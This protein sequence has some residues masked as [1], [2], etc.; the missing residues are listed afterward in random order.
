MPADPAGL[1]NVGPIF[2]TPD[3]GTTVYSYTRLLSD[4][5]DGRTMKRLAGFAL[6]TFMAAAALADDAPRPD[7][8]RDALLSFTREVLRQ[9]ANERVEVDLGAIDVYKFGTHLKFLWLPFLA[10]L[11]G[12]KLN[13]TANLPDPFALTNTRIARSMPY[14]AEENA[15]SVNREIRRVLKLDKKRAKVKVKAE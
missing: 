3:G 13:E 2:V 15:S 5:P 12:T 7:Y 4:L 10:P 6:L 8:S 11:P 9:R 1:T 14:V